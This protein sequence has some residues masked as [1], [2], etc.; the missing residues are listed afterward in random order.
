MKY[1]GFDILAGPNVD[2]TGDIHRLS[3]Y[4]PKN[5]VDVIFSMS[6]FEHLAMPWK[7][8]IEM[9][10]VLKPGGVMFHTSHQTWPIHEIPWDYWR[11][12][13]YS[14]KSLLNKR[15]G[16]EIIATAMGEEAF[17]H[18][19]IKHANLG[20]IDQCPCFLGSAVTC[21][22]I[23]ETSLEWEVNVSDIEEDAYPN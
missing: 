18:P 11:F 6:V 5:S 19:K 4:F 23:A 3:A 9:N 14:W 1:T 17:L 15:T 20:N 8:V 2:I 16:F 12:S 10:R 22:K 7:A 21:R 13:S